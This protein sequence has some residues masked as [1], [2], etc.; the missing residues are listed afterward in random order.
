[1]DLQYVAARYNSWRRSDRKLKKLV[2]S[3][4]YYFFKQRM[5]NRVM[6]LGNKAKF[7]EIYKNNLWNNEESL[8]GGGSTLKNTRNVRTRLPELIDE[9][10]IGS[11]LDAGCGDFH[12]MK[13]IEID[14]PYFGIDI[15]KE[16]IETNRRRYGGPKR[17]F[18]ELDI[19]SDELPAA[20]LIMCRECLFHLSFDDIVASVVNFKKSG[21]KY[22][23]ATTYPTVEDNVDVAS[24]LCRALNFQRAPLN[25]PRALEMIE[26][27]R[28]GDQWL[29]LWALDEINAEVLGRARAS[30]SV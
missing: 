26:E 10:G 19:T 2:V 21:A 16:M 29:G 30:A 22:L 24:G 4:N 15:V 6:T 23:L 20:D 1:M 8:S 17:T 28:G 25:F 18:M 3:L 27:N 5:W 9:R 13:E 12:W 7:T 11:I 14:V